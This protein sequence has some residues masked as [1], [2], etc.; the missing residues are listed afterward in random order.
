MRCKSSAVN[1]LV[2]TASISDACEGNDTGSAFSDEPEGQQKMSGVYVSQHLSFLM[3]R[4]TFRGKSG[5]ERYSGNPTVADRRG[6]C[7]NVDDGKVAR[8]A[9]L[10]RPPRQRKLHDPERPATRLHK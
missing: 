1:C 6:A 4:K 7:G 8:A 3:F 5:S 10:S 9:V 2:R